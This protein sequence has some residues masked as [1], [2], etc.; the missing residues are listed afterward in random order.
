MLLHY[1]WGILKNLVMF[2]SPEQVI[3]SCEFFLL[4]SVLSALPLLSH[5]MQSSSTTQCTPEMLL[6]NLNSTSRAVM[7]SWEIE[8]WSIKNDYLKYQNMIVFVFQFERRWMLFKGFLWLIISA[9]QNCWFCRD[10]Y[11]YLCF[12]RQNRCHTEAMS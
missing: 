6:T 12:W 8:I 9:R 2:P 7:R 1:F 5:I 3:F 10:N 4:S 11:Y